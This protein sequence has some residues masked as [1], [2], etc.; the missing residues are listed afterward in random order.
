MLSWFNAVKQGANDDYFMFSSVYIY[1]VYYHPLLL[2]SSPP[3]GLLLQLQS[4]LQSRPHSSSV[5]TSVDIKFLLIPLA[6]LLLRLGSMVV[7]IVYV[8]AQATISLLATYIL[9]CIAVSM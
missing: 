9:L 3:V 8:Y 1:S 7:V 2:S 5:V 4:T 6:F